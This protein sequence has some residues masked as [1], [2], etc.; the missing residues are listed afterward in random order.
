M[1]F[2]FIA[3]AG[4]A[5]VITM[6]GLFAW[7]ELWAQISDYAWWGLCIAILPPVLIAL[8]AVVEIIK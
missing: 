4:C 5:V 3:A 6:A 1:D 8:Y 7:S 2:I